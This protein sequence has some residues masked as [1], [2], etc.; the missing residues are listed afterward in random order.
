MNI[1]I[2]K[3]EYFLS[4]NIKFFKARSLK[5]LIVIFTIFAI[6]G[7]IAVYSSKNLLLLLNLDPSVVSQHFYWPVRLLVLLIAYQFIL[8]FVS[9]VFGEFDHF[10]RYSLKYISG[11]RKN[12]PAGDS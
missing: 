2:E 12:K 9:S 4:L 5:H 6:S 3:F 10:S 8:L 1:F 7:S 11:L